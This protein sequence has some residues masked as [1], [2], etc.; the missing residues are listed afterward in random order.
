MG[1]KVAEYSTT[2]IN[3]PSNSQFTV[4]WYSL[5][6]ASKMASNFVVVVVV[7]VVQWTLLQNISNIESIEIHK[8]KQTMFS[9]P[10]FSFHAHVCKALRAF[11]IHLFHLL[12]RHR[13]VIVQIFIY[14][15][16]ISLSPFLSLSLFSQFHFTCIMHLSIYL[17]FIANKQVVKSKDSYTYYFL[18]LYLTYFTFLIYTILLPM[19]IHIV[20]FITLI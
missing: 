4:S 14:N 2:R 16:S 12:S 15:N 10:H 6:G 3:C 13:I 18:L 7:V 5:S 8:H 19:K 9:F 1:I 11:G 20:L 17:L